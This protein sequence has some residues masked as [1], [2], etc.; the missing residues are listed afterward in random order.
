K[1]DLPLALKQ[2]G[3]RAVGTQVAA[4]LAEGMT[5]FGSGT[6]AVV[7]H[8]L[9]IHRHAGNTVTLIGQLFDVVSIVGAGTPG[10]GTI[11]H[12][13]A[14][15]GAQRLVHRQTQAR[16]IGNN[17]ATGLGGNGQLTD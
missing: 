1:Q 16:V 2:V 7:G 15:I 6:V 8:G 10:N 5:H 12:V 11:N 17:A 9:D 14:H 3:D 4:V 13:T